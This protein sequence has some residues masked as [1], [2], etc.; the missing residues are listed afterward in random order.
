MK[1]VVESIPII[2]S[3]ETW[4]ASQADSMVTIIDLCSG[5]GYLSMILSEYLPPT[6]VTKIVLID[7]AWPMCHS[8][9]QSHHINWDHIYGNYTTTESEQTKT[10]SSYFTTWPIPL[11]TSKQDLKSKSTFRQLT[12]RLSSEGNPTMILGVHLCGT[13]SIQ[14]IRLFHSVEN[15]EG[16]ILKPCCLP[17]IAH[18]SSEHFVV[19]TYSFP[20]KDVCSVGK[21]SKKEWDGPPRWH[22]Q[23]KFNSWCRHLRHGM[24]GVEGV[25]TELVEI[26][27]QN[28][29]GF[30]NTFLFAEKKRSRREE[31]RP[32]QQQ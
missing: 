6:K 27:V 19:G 12:Q 9:P 18:T 29:G 17:G 10:S 11:H 25:T 1:E 26:P 15:V 2:S 16:L 8:E 7:K 5:K 21:W 14:A 22:L 31:P 3:V 32:H 28:N 23:P 4:V 30:Q 20:T 24:Q 13:L